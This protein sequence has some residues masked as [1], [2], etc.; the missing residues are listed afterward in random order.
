[1]ASCKE[2]TERVQQVEEGGAAS[3]APC[4]PTSKAHGSLEP[5]LPAGQRVGLRLSLGQRAWVPGM[6]LLA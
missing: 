6:V 2:G 5:C 4:S 1:M 3:G